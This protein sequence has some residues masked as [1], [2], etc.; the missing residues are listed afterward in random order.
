MQQLKESQLEENYCKVESEEW[1]ASSWYTYSF[2][3]DGWG[4]N[5]R[6]SP[7]FAR[8]LKVQKGGR[9]GLRKKL[10]QKKKKER[11]KRR[12][13]WKRKRTR[14]RWEGVD[15][16]VQ[17][18]MMVEGRGMRDWFPRGVGWE[19]RLKKRRH[20][21]GCDGCFLFE[22]RA[23][24]SH[25]CKSGRKE[26]RTRLNLQPVGASPCWERHSSGYRRAC[27]RGVLR[28]RSWRNILKRND[29]GMNFKKLCGKDKNDRRISDGK[30]GRNV[31]KSL[32]YARRGHTQ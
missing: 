24:N 17:D 12:C 29:H 13:T 3:G 22:R 31:I 30:P 9:K 5:A 28:N 10:E 20:G 6:A 11:E 8:R 4:T 7:R 2:S 14:E 1:R 21:G 25:A 16:V 23:L 32:L 26:G 27:A 15:V 19:G 18:S